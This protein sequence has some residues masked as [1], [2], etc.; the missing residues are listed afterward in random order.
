[1][2]SEADRQLSLLR[3]PVSLA[4]KHQ[5]RA[6]FKGIPKEVPR[7]RRQ[8]KFECWFRHAKTTFRSHILAKAG[9]FAEETSET[10]GQLGMVETKKDETQRVL[11]QVTP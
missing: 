10:L 11:P 4:G 1:M 3:H 8:I 5:L 2:Q 6:A 9:K 7:R